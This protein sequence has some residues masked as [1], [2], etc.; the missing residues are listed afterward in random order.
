MG[1]E[2]FQSQFK[3]SILKRHDT[4]RREENVE[5][6]IECEKGWLKFDFLSQRGGAQRRGMMDAQMISR[7]VMIEVRIE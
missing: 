6:G 4:Q 7:I 5:V 2:G 3:I 1:R